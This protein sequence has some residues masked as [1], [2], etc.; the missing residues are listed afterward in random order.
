MKVLLHYAA[1]PQLRAEMAALAAQGLE[2][3]CCAE[4]PEEPFGSELPDAEV[5]WHVLQPIT[6]EVIARAPRLRL[7]HKIGVGVN[8][9]DLEAAKARGVAVCNMPGSNSRAVAEMSLMLMLN[10]LRRQHRVEQSLRAGQWTVDE[11]TRES[12]GELAGRT[13]GIVGFGAVPR[14]LAPILEAM[15]ARVVYTAKA[16]MSVPWQYLPLDELLGEADIVTLHVPLSEATVRLI[17]RARIARMKRG[18]VL[19]NT[20]RGALVD[21]PALYAA[22]ASGHLGSAGLDVFATEP[23]APDNPLLTLP[24]VTVTPH[25]AWLTAETWQRSIGVAVANALAL[26]DGAPLA[27]RVA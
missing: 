6:A 9:I 4:G 15:G 10:A 13:V 22:L 7:I 24:N 16:P 25:V 17:D 18:A 19:V 20:A 14:I 27:H 23:L 3:V 2:V 26:R 1:G 21:E 11:A 5:I 8:T 12:F